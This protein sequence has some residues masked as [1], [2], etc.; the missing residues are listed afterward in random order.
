TTF[1]IMATG[2]KP[3]PSC[4]YGHAGIDAVLALRS[5]Y[6][7]RP[8]EVDS[9]SYG[10]SRAGLLLV[11]A[12]I[13]AKRNPETLV[14][15]QFSAPFVLATALATGKMGWDSYQS[16]H[17]P[18][19][20]SLMARID[21]V[22]DPEIEAEFPANMSGRIVIKARGET[23]SQKVIVPLGEPSNFLDTKALLAK[24]QGLA[25][26][27]LGTRWQSLAEAGLR[28]D[29]L[30]DMPCLFDSAATTPG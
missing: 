2:I 24:F 13:G 15:A 20:R 12:P 11:G 29:L 6:A 26:P 25:E 27:V 3:Y 30:P 17:D 10:L 14:G 23:F 21:C 8:E 7:L 1:E 22:H 19:I 4:R 5:R 16:L 9:I 28:I 18:A